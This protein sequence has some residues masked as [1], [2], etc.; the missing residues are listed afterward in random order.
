LSH[1][2]VR[3]IDIAQDGSLWI[4]MQGG[5]LD[6]FD[7]VSQTFTHF[8]PEQGNP[9][10]LVSE[11]VFAVVIDSFGKIWVGTE[12]GLSCLDPKTGIFTNYISGKIDFNTR[13]IYQDEQGMIWIGT[14]SGLHLFNQELQTF[15]SYNTDDGLA[16][17]MVV[18]IIAD[19]QG[20]LWIG[21]NKGLSKFDTTRKKFRNYDSRDGLQGNQFRR[22][23]VYKS[24]QGELYFGGVNG[25]NSF[26][27]EKVIDNPHI[28]PVVLTD[29]QLFNQPVSIGGNS[30]LQQHINV[31]EHITLS[32]DQSVFSIK[33][34]ALNYQDSKKNQFAY[35]MEGFDKNFT[36]TDSSSPHAKYTNLDPGDYTFVV[37][38]SN[39]DGIWNEEGTSIKIKI[40]PPWWKTV[41]FRILFL[42]GLLGL[43]WAIFQ[44][45]LSAINAHRRQLEVEI[46]ERKQTE[47]A[48][49]TIQERL[50]LATQASNTGIW[51]WDVV[52]N[53]LTWDDSM[54]TLYGI[55][56]GDFSGV[57]DAWSRMVFQEDRQYAEAEIQAALRGERQYDIIYRI[58]RP[59]DTIRVLIAS[60][61]T[62]FDEN[63]KPL[64]MIG[65]NVDIT[66]LKQAEEDLK[67]QQLLLEKAQELGQLGSWEFDLEENLFN[68][69]DENCQIFG[70]PSGTIPKHDIFVEKLHPD[71][72]EYVGREWE[73]ALE[74]KPYD[75][76]H[77]IVVDG[78]TKWVREKA[79]VD[80]DED[81]KAVKGTG[82]TQDITE[83]KQLEDDL[84]Q[85][86]KMESVGTLAG[87]VAH[88]FNNILGGILGYTE[89]AKEDA[90]EDS[91]V[92]ESLDEIFKLSIR[93]RDVVKQILSFSRKGEKEHKPLQPHLVIEESLKVLR[94]TIPTSIEIRHSIDKN[95]G[96]IMANSTQIHQVGMNLCMNAT[97]AME[98]K[99]GVL[100]VGLVPVVIDAEDV[101]KSPDLK[102]GEYVK[103]TVTDTG[104][105]INP[106]NISKIY[107][108]FFSTKD[109]GKGTGMGLSVVHG[110]VKDHGGAITVNSREGQGT[111]F[112]V[113]LP[114]IEAT[115]EEKKND[116]AIP[117]GTENILVVDDEEHLVLLMK[118]ML[119]RLGYK[120]TA[121]TSS[122]E[123]LELFKK[124]PQRYDLIITDLTMPH[125][126][127]DRLALE[128][129]T[130]RPDMPVII[131]TGYSD[132]V[133]NDKVKQ[134][135]IK[136][137]I[138]K[139]YQKQELAKTIRLILDG[140]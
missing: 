51:D 65:T 9:N 123:M 127:G 21:T 57:Y 42:V 95:S 3:D 136:A 43:I 55:N 125:L 104:S 68:W 34:A 126:T 134:S 100:E 112:S 2:S 40:L 5:G 62:Y 102:T 46:K 105:G 135:G 115:I 35:M 109:V 118:K 50:L 131:A 70:V 129:T 69:T 87:G 137:F 6:R 84:R 32:H 117:K 15:T 85:S 1:G 77:R 98:D 130:I 29:F 26:F 124:D 92:R 18:S 56:S 19:N 94:A 61:Q 67:R 121:L 16:G 110:I 73:A 53:T 17:D 63:G 72:R 101:K 89:I 86:Q 11:W 22:D 122:L 76:E 10:S 140:K 64:R 91:S 27:P 90:P 83:R 47:E 44:W 74:G 14:N 60:A 132:A 13:T 38:G 75:I 80:F 88:E 96:T 81:G 20:Y 108:P 4:G 66:E 99:G 120:V 30:P 24:P 33:F 31:S 36:Y 45:R 39:N 49:Q 114:R 25:F 103:L 52:N 37:K 28:P 133:D 119:E 59:D 8:L 78:K 106:K 58:M 71:D 97:H 139:P 48:L 138:P 79:N 12:G 113:F 54:Y 128:V 116:D 107:D 7:P 111:T 41:W 23:A 82:F 93:A